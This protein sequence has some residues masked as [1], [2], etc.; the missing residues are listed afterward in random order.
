MTKQVTDFTPEELLAQGADFFKAALKDLDHTNSASDVENEVEGLLQDSRDEDSDYSDLY[1]SN[2]DFGSPKDPMEELKLLEA[3]VDGY[4][5][6]DDVEER[7]FEDD[8]KRDIFAENDD[9]GMDTDEEAMLTTY[10]RQKA[11]LM[12]EARQLEDENVRERDWVLRGEVNARSRPENSLLEEDL[13]FDF[14]MVPPPVITPEV[15]ESIEDVIKRRVKERVFDNPILPKTA[16]EQTEADKW[17]EK[18]R[19]IEQEMTERRDLGQ[20]YEDEFLKRQRQHIQT[21]DQLEQ[22]YGSALDPTLKGKY[23][24]LEALYAKIVTGIDGMLYK[25]TQIR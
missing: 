9:S 16:E 18:R 11:K 23:E 3:P 19:R 4:N 2:S 14:T 25:S 5:E 13:E 7:W 20:L 22:L 10:Q 17:Q 21:K 6:D 15:T 12:Q 24:D 8:E 1:G